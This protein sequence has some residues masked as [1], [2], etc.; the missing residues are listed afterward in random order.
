MVQVIKGGRS[1]LPKRQENLYEKE[2]RECG[3]KNEDRLGIL[4]SGQETCLILGGMRG[5]V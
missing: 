5:R 2:E 4:Y 1:L 3:G